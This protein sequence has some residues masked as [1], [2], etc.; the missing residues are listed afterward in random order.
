MLDR[1]TVRI[2][3]YPGRFGFQM[4][5]RRRK[6][7]LRSR[8]AQT[9]PVISA[10][11][12]RSSILA[13]GELTAREAERVEWDVIVVGTGMGGGMLGYWLARSGRR[14][15]FVEKGRSTLPGTPG[16]I[17]SAMPEL[18]EPLAARS[19]EAYY[20]ALARAGRSTDEVEDIS[21][22]FPKRFV[23][24]IGSGTGGSSA[25]YGM[26]CERFFARDFTPRQNFRRPRRFHRAGGLAGHLRPDAALVRGGRKAAA[27]FAAS[28]IPCGRRRPTSICLRHHRFRPTTSRW[29]TIWQGADCIPITCRWPV[30]TP[31][32]APPVR[33]ISATSRARTTPPAM[34]CCRPSPSTAPSC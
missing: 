26:V 3:F 28:P 27:G 24:F 10:I 22:R 31:T 20:D 5:P 1:R 11:T 18:A 21:G 32:T 7:M 25:L 13:D 19:A 34:A 4:W 8:I 16:T 17:R 23:P 9:R 6:R 30:I 29:S 14:V 12:L 15:L 2:N 33:P